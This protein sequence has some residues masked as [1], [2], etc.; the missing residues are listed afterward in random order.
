MRGAARMSGRRG[1]RR[2][3]RLDRRRRCSVLFYFSAVWDWELGWN[4]NWGGVTACM[5]AEETIGEI[6]ALHYGLEPVYVTV[7]RDEVVR[8]NVSRPVA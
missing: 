1:R 3:R 6:I 2:N 4:K 8:V 7:L 5:D